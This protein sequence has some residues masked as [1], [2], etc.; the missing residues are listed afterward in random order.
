M[1]QDL[2]FAFRQLIKSPGFTTVVVLTLALGIGSTTTVFCWMQ[3]IWLNPLPGVAGQEQMYVV[4]PTRG[5]LR[6]HTLSFPDIQDLRAQKDIFAGVIGSQV[7]PASIT[8]DDRPIWI[9]GQ[10]ATANFFDVLGVRPILGRTFLPD[11]D[12]KPS[13][14][15]A[16]VLSETCWQRHF[17]ADPSVVGRKVLLNRH[18][19][20]I[21]GVVPAAFHGTMSGLVSD[22]W[23][24][25]SMHK[26]V[27][28]G[29]SMI[30]RSWRWFHTQARLQ[31]GVTQA[32]AQASLDLL[33][34]RLQQTYPDTNKG[35]SFKIL[36]F[37][38]APYGVQ[39]VLLPTL[40]ILLVVSMGVLLIVAANVA[41]LLLAR[42]S[43]REKEIA[44][45]LAVGAGRMRL[46]R[47]LLVESL[48]LAGVGGILGVVFSFWM[49][50]LLAAMIP[51]TN[52]PVG[53]VCAIDAKTL[54]FASLITLGI[55]TIFGLI[56]AWQVTRPD[57]NSTLKEGGRGSGGA[58]SQHR[59]R[60]L[61][62][63]AEVALSLSLLIG[64]GLCIRSA[65]RAREADFGFD[66]NH[67]LL[68]GLRIGMNGYNEQ[69]G[70]VFY[71]QLQQRLAALPGVENVAL[72][73]WFP[74][75]F[76]RGG[77]REVSPEGYVARPG[78]DMSVPRVIVSP[79]YF[80]TMK[81][82]LM[83]GREF[84]EQDDT[85]S[86]RVAVI[87]EAMARRYWPG[88]NPVGRTL[89]LVGDQ[90][91]LTIVGMVKT[92][93]YYLL[94]EKPEPF[95]FT[96][97]QQGAGDLDL[98]I[99]IRTRG[100][101][102]A[103]AATVREE[104]QRLDPGVAAWSTQPMRDYMK[105]AF[106]A[107]G[108]ASRLLTAMGLLALALAAMGVY[109]V[110]AYAVGERMREFGLRMALG[111]TPGSLL[112]LVLK[113]GLLLASWGIALGLVLA[114]AITRLLASFL[115]NVSPFDPVTFIGVPLLLAAIAIIAA[116]V[117][118]RRAMR[119]DPCT[120]L[121]SE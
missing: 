58:R 112:S 39:P 29:G 81:A 107:P 87:N 7:T 45:R 26:E 117:P 6:S 85:D 104:I 77:S 94:S 49:V 24:P 89:L 48:V 95:F 9:Y 30:H 72:A 106:T 56:P 111:A 31:P 103:F 60:R 23:A 19:F 35:L 110:M 74:L 82:P 18:P 92:G 118:A 28:N 71:R 47:Q 15:P 10:P 3:S 37:S 57:L 116:L 73:N 86:Q 93:K 55:G 76:E 8:L 84:T 102:E 50:D 83:E 1:F 2:R 61:L 67:V 88:Q 90:K 40:R 109:A 59:L 64:A 69:S 100:S 108:L 38:E 120:A 25:A 27:M 32:Q 42:A 119:A 44:I 79:G 66:P 62:V 75:G 80:A 34:A 105:A 54:G 52:L 11:E 21:V 53:I 4:V 98:G 16:L 113:N 17:G 51:P 65:S 97:V 70:K 78:E 46:I 91:P 101:P 13:G 121:R 114:I 43:G 12:S 14:N 33:S 115:Y 22:F 20:T 41:N 99:A 5:D 63:I 68:T 36:R 96:P